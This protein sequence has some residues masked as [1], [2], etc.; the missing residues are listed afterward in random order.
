[1]QQTTNDLK[2]TTEIKEQAGIISE[3]LTSVESKVNNTKI[4]GRNVVLG[5]SIPASLIGSNT[6]NQTL[7]IYNFAGGDSS[8]IIDKEIC[9][10]FDWKVE[11]TTTPSGTMYM[12]G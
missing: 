8:S 4:G 6:A 3:K 10:S 7:S 12:Q 9:V 5:T 2:T 1:M 11:G